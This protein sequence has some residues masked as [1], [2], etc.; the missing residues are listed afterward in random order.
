MTTFR[1]CFDLFSFILGCWAI[2]SSGLPACLLL[3][4]SGDEIET[5]AAA[6]ADDDG[7]G[8]DDDGKDEE[9]DD[10]DWACPRGMGKTG[11]TTGSF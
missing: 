2:Y 9:D 1:S 4:E 11:A 5:A 10:G 6:A 3:L 8:D 7:N